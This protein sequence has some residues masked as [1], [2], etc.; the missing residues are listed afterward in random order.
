[1][2]WMPWHQQAMKG[3]ASCEKPRGVANRL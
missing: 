3:V 2:R 1:V